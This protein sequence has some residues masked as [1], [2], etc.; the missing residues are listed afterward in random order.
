MYDHNLY[1]LELAIKLYPFD[2]RYREGFILVADLDD[3]LISPLLQI[4]KLE[5]K[6]INLKRIL[7][8]HMMNVHDY[9]GAEEKFKELYDLAPNSSFVQYLLSQR[10]IP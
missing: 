4:E 9:K 10:K 7:I 8:N 1:K 6:S 2:F 5:P 3:L